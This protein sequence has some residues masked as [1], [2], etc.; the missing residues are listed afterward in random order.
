MSNCLRSVICILLSGIIFVFLFAFPHVAS[1]ES[2]QDELNIKRDEEK[3]VY[4]IGSSHADKKDQAEEDKE[5]S[6]EMLKNMNLWMKN[7]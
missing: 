5:N 7:K 1:S 3:T 4:T 6:W 2:G